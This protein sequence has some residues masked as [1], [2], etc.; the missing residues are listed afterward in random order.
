MIPVEHLVICECLDTGYTI[1]TNRNARVSMRLFG[2]ND[3]HIAAAKS[4][5]KM[6]PR[7]DWMLLDMSE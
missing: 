3:A 6:A 4:P 1:E 5:R 7:F 2:H